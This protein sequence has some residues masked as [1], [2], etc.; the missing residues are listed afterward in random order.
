MSKR[1]ALDDSDDGLLNTPSVYGTGRRQ[2]KIKPRS[3]IL[4]RK[5]K[6]KYTVHGIVWHP[7]VV[8]NL[9]RV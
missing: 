3:S 5:K 4:V 1:P 8:F 7:S 2:R 6:S 9:C